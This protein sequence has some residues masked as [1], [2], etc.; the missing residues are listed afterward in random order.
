MT[1]SSI[2]HVL[3]LSEDIEGTRH[4]YRD[5]IGLDVG[6]YDELRSRQPMI[7]VRSR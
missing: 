7:N 1:V 3:V 6:D 4:F 5:V 2:E